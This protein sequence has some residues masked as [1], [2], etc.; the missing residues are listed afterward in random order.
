MCTSS[1]YSAFSGCR[2][3]FLFGLISCHSLFLFQSIHFKFLPK[4]F[5]LTKHFLWTFFSSNTLLS[6]RFLFPLSS[7]FFFFSMSGHFLFLSLSSHFFFLS[8]PQL[9]SFLQ[10]P[11]WLLILF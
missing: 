2:P 4:S 7:Q 3:T 9:L 6:K 1:T 5:F 8:L 10:P 11:F